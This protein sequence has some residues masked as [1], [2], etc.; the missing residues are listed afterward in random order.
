[1]QEN[2]FSAGTTRDMT[3]NGINSGADVNAV[4]DVVFYTDG[5]FDEQ[6]KEG[7]KRI[8]VE[9]Q[10]E[11]L[12]IKKANEIIRGALADSA[13]DHPTATAIE[14]LAKAAVAATT[15]KPDGP[16]D[17]VQGQ[18]MSLQREIANV[19]NVQEPGRAQQ[20]TTERE[21]LTQYVEEQEKRVEL[22][23]PHCHLE[24]TLK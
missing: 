6:N 8:V 7:F 16:Y 11:L 13:N 22:M 23:T 21:R 15:H 14:E 1:M 24:V 10:R 5:T 2:V 18:E 4:A 19:G 17:P 20:G 3:L 12:A 9:R